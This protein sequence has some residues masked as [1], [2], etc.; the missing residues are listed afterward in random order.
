MRNSANYS[1]EVIDH[2]GVSTSA[3]RTLHTIYPRVPRPRIELVRSSRPS[4][5]NNPTL[6]LSLNGVLAALQG[7][8][9]SISQNITS[10][11]GSTQYQISSNTTS[12]AFPGFHVALK[13]ST[14]TEVAFKSCVHRPAPVSFG[15]HCQG[16]ATPDK[17][18]LLKYYYF[19]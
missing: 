15:R 11:L 8:D 19:I 2:C 9:T 6:L 3:Q 16:L 5:T 18:Y 4:S 14:C 10:R 17:M 12:M 1:L 13:H 7:F